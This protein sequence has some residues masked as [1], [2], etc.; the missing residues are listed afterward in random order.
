MEARNELLTYLGAAIATVVGLFGMQYWYASYLDVDVVHAQS[1]YAPRDARVIAVRNQET[2]KLTSGKLSVDAAM[3]Q[4]AQRGRTAFPLIAPQP[5]DDLT[6]M[7]GWIHQP[8][9][10]PYEPRKPALAQAQLAPAAEG[11]G[12]TDVTQSRAGASRQRSLV[13]S[14]GATEGAAPATAEQPA[15]AAQPAAAQPAQEGKAP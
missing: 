4:L 2:Q 11:T 9:F 14:T 15:A 5:S 13:T 3:H 1:P 7:S 6:P 8:G 10:K 12:A